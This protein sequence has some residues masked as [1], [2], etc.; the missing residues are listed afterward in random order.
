MVALSSGGASGHVGADAEMREKGRGMAQAEEI[1]RLECSP[2]GEESMGFDIKIDRGRDG[3]ERLAGTWERLAS[4]SGRQH[5]FE[6]WWYYR[7]C[8]GALESS[9]D[10]FWFVSVLDGGE[11]KVILPLEQRTVRRAGM[12]IKALGS[13]RSIY[14]P[15]WDWI[16][17]PGEEGA[18]LLVAVFDATQGATLPCDMMQFGAVFIDSSFRQAAEGLEGYRGFERKAAPSCNYLCVD[19]AQDPLGSLSRNFRGNLR[20]ARNKLKALSSVSIERFTEGPGLQEALAR[21]VELEASGWKGAEA[22]TI[23]DKPEVRR[24]YE[25]LLEEYARD[26]EGGCHI[27][28]LVVDG[29]TIAGQLCL[30]MRDTLYILKIAYDE[31]FKKMAPGN[32]LLEWLIESCCSD[33][34]M[35]YLSFVSEYPWQEDWNPRA[36]ACEEMKFY[37]AS[38]LGRV[39]RL[40][41]YG[42]KVLGVNTS[43]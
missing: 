15:F 28:E 34:T 23:R 31:D 24:F 3:L 21:F 20:K 14:I 33:A 36:L 9:G 38:T 37:A 18:R 27:N 12:S 5:F 2:M 32:M 11:V 7:A 1:N 17:E 19:G 29:R 30:R 16:G 40:K 25:R 8:L 39:L 43:A 10:H 35:R 4:R 26:A 42:Q 13:P 6:S 22:S 41:S